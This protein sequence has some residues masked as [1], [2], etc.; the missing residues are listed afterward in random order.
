MT[1]KQTN[2]AVLFVAFPYM[3]AVIEIK[4]VSD[5]FIQSL[6]EI[7]PFD[8]WTKIPKVFA[9]GEKNARILKKIFRI[10]I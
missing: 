7:D 9:W 3:I 2:L 8:E 6:T 5:F 10:D 1:F 4:Q